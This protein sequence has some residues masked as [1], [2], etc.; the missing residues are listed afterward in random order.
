MT[1]F[2]GS[3]AENGLTTLAN[4]LVESNEKVK[5]IDH[6]LDHT[7]NVNMSQ[8]IVLSSLLFG[9]IYMFS[10]SVIGINKMFMKDGERKP[11]YPFLIINGSIMI[12]SGLTLSIFSFKAY[13]MAMISRKH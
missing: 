13:P 7:L 3:F 1:G 9:S 2:Y 12:I 5:T 8:A 4:K 11:N 6:T 10:V